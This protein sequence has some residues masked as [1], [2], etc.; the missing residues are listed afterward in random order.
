MASNV[1]RGVDGI[2]VLCEKVFDMFLLL[3]LLDLEDRSLGV[4]PSKYPNSVFSV[5][6]CSEK[7]FTHL[8]IF[9]FLLCYMYTTC[10]L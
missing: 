4:I 8:H 9:A 2:L 6:Y 7:I 10:P 1:Y 3:L 5:K